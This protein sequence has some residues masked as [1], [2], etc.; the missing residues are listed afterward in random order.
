MRFLVGSYNHSKEIF[1]TSIITMKSTEKGI[2]RVGLLI[3]SVTQ[4]RWVYKIVED[5]SKA[6]ICEIVLVVKNQDIRE[7][8]YERFFHA[9]MNKRQYVLWKIY[10]II[11]DLIFKSKP[12]AF[13]KM[14][15]SPFL[16]G[17]P[18]L[19][20]RP[21]KKGHSDFFQ[22]QDVSSILT[23]SLD[24][25]IRFGFRILRGGI[26][27][28]ATY[29][30]WSFHH[31]DNRMNR[32]GPPGFWEVMTETPVT[33]SILQ[34]LAPE[35]D[36]GKILYRSWSSTSQYSVRRNKNN[37]YWKSSSFVIRKLKEL[38]ESGKLPL[39]DEDR[40]SAYV[41]YSGPLYKKPSNSQMIRLGIKMSGKLIS[42]IFQECFYHKQWFL[43]FKIGKAKGISDTFY[44]FKSMLPPRD[45]FWA[46]P[47]PV[48]KEGAYYIFI[49]EYMYS[50]NKAH[51]SVIQ[52]DKTGSWSNPVK[53]L[54][55]DF[56]LSYPF[57]FKWNSEY[58]MVPESGSN[59]TVKLYRSVCFPFEWKLEDVFMENVRAVD[60][61]LMEIDGLWWMF[62]NIAEEG[63][64][65]CDELHLFYSDKPFGPWKPH[66]R[67]P[68]KSDIRSSRPAG[69][70]FYWN[71]ELYRPAQD[72]SF[73]GGYGISINKVIHISP[74][75]YKEEEVSKIRP[76][77]KNNLVG[78]HTLNH[79][80]R[81]T[82]IDS[83]MYSRRFI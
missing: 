60:A 82:L 34:V 78:I 54:E 66:K 52:M 36:A 37:Y 59:R 16:N 49:E 9:L 62:V 69:N 79:T 18:V 29:G 47:F 12:D 57:I 25:A 7:N 80:G 10:S 22:E 65:T 40:E 83:A 46:D 71:G 63:A 11:D 30:V 74:S 58:Y 1:V 5:I 38:H 8:P 27:D 3:D 55:T 50:L 81:L 64:S 73:L 70:L 32:G 31:A 28:I 15:I 68:V 17:C 33:G 6:P 21:I 44:D 75:N 20:V 24:V 4:P 41:P 72:C 2:L 45:R 23:H 42:K 61:S 77:W 67:N 53:V 35:L 13:Q 14:D 56:H 26:L 39:N 76:S 51:I 43:A 19:P 48:E